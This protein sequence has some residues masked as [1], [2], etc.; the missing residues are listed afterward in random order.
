MLQRE[1]FYI[2]W[3][4][5]NL[6]LDNF[7]FH[8][9]YFLFFSLSFFIQPLPTKVWFFL[10]HFH[11]WLRCHYHCCDNF[12]FMLFS[13]PNKIFGFLECWLFPINRVLFSICRK[14]TQLNGCYY[15]YFDVG[16]C[17]CLDCWYC[18]FFES[19]W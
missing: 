8:R 10:N 5:L 19:M 1:K 13:F 18:W 6:Q 7:I 4:L 11:Q 9:F 14:V 3:Q 12:I 15:C 17:G 16:Y 2:Y